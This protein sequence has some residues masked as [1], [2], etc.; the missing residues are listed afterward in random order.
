VPEPAAVSIGASE[1][2]EYIAKTSRAES[3]S[4]AQN[5]P[6]TKKP[7][8]ESAMAIATAISEVRAQASTLGLQWADQYQ[9][10]CRDVVYGYCIGERTV[11]VGRGVSGY[12]A[13][14]LQYHDEG[15]TTETV[16]IADQSYEVNPSNA[17]AKVAILKELH[18]I[19]ASATWENA[20]NRVGAWSEL[21]KAREEARAAQLQREKDRVESDYSRAKQEH[22]S[23]V[24][25]KQ[26]ARTWA[27]MGAG[28]ALAG[29]MILGLIL[30]VLAIERHTRMLEA[31]MKI[32]ATGNVRMQLTPSSAE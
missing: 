5:A 10:R 19:L 13:E 25:L 12:I 8:S 9:R 20:A 17:P 22:E 11:R 7:P 15:E 2:D 1:V 31:A 23:S 30:A 26:T 29:F 3:K 6:A 28:L 21:R 4:E 24:A 16:S 18:S 27:I 14:A 32:A